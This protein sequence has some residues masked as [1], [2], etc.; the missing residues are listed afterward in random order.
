MR[1]KYDGLQAFSP[2]KKF[3]GKFSLNMFAALRQKL[4]SNDEVRVLKGLWKVEKNR[5]NEKRD[6]V[7][8]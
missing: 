1:K 5:S 4:S 2:V 6:Y 3:L 7:G 8:N